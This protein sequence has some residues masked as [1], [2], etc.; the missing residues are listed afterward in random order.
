MVHFS[1]KEE[2]SP[3]QRRRAARRQTFLE[4]AFALIEKK[5]LDGLTIQALAT[6]TDY[7]VGALYRYFPSKQALLATLQHQALDDLRRT[8]EKNLKRPCHC[9]CGRPATECCQPLAGPLLCAESLLDWTRDRSVYFGLLTLSLGDPR[10]LLEGEDSAMVVRAAIPLVGRIAA[11]LDLTARE[12]TFTS[13]N[14]TDRA[15]MLWMSLTGILQLEKM[16]DRFAGYVAARRQAEQLICDLFA[17]WGADPDK[18]RRTVRFF[19][20]S[21]SIFEPESDPEPNKEQ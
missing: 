8:L 16:T 17:G 3:R 1:E 9:G 13:G 4:A 20:I 11:A 21:F 15:M 6:A 19:H 12:G 2:Q 5:G 7:S 14:S 18:I 10:R